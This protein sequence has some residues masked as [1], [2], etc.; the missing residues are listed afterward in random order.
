MGRSFLTLQDRAASHADPIQ[1]MVCQRRPMFAM[2]HRSAAANCTHALSVVDYRAACE[3][4]NVNTLMI[5]ISIPSKLLHYLGYQR[6]QSMLTGMPE[7]I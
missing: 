3:T 6:R 5:P 1:R 4:N 2:Q 7:M